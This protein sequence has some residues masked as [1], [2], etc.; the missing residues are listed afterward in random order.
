DYND[1]VGRIAVGKVVSGALRPNQEVVLLRRGV[2]D[3]KASLS[4][5]YAYE[6]LNRVSR[7]VVE[8]GDIAAVAGVPDAFIG[9]TLGDPSDP[10]PLPSITVEEPTLS[11]V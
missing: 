9:D 7:E 8:A 1:Y 6:G 4:Q 2:A 11:M 5:V 10:R 3:S